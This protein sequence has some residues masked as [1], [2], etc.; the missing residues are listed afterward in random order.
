MRRSCPP[1]TNRMIERLHRHLVAHGRLT[2][3]QAAEIARSSHMAVEIAPEWRIIAEAHALMDL[4]AWISRE[5]MR[6][7]APGERRAQSMDD[8]IGDT[9]DRIHWIERRQGQQH[10]ST[11]QRWLR[12]TD[13]EGGDAA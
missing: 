6:T 9:V 1:A 11:R 5:V 10:E 13:P 8:V 4:A 7:R 12:R 3:R 2:E